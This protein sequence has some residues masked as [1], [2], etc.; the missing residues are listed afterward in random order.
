MTTTS[1][2]DWAVEAGAAISEGPMRVRGAS[3]TAQSGG[4]LAFALSPFLR[5][6]YASEKSLDRL[7][8][9]GDT[10]PSRRTPTA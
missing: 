10:P 4:I 7:P 5:L 6:T 8:A 9:Q 2:E 1:G 3:V